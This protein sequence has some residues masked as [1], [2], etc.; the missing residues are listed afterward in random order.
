MSEILKCPSVD[1]SSP[2]P[3]LHP[4][5]CL[6][7]QITFLL[8]QCCV[9]R[10]CVSAR[11]EQQRKKR[12]MHE[13][14]WTARPGLCTNHYISG[15]NPNQEGGRVFLLCGQFTCMTVSVTLWSWR[16][17]ET[18]RSSRSIVSCWIRVKNAPWPC[19]FPSCMWLNIDACPSFGVSALMRCAQC[20]PKALCFTIHG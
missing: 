10:R 20:V 5:L 11:L 9:S 13:A 14:W 16:V 1:L 2:P 19:F 15:N 6:Q 7:N 3:T 4:S 18:C 17:W 12:T 8:F